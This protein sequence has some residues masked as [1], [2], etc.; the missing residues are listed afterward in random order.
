MDD[1]LEEC[2]EKLI[3][4]ALLLVF[5][6]HALPFLALLHTRDFRAQLLEFVQEI[7]LRRLNTALLSRGLALLRGSSALPT[8]TLLLLLA[9]LLLLL[10]PLSLELLELLAHGLQLSPQLLLHLVVV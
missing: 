4:A 2:E 9:L 5:L 7:L 3:R 10:L 1:P 6:A 8:L